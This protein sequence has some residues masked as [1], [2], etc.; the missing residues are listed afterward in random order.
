METLHARPESCASAVSAGRTTPSSDAGS[1]SGCSSRQL[2][3]ALL[4]PAPPSGPLVNGDTRSTDF[5][6]ESAPPLQDVPNL[7]ALLPHMF[8]YF[9][10]ATRAS[11][12]RSKSRPTHPLLAG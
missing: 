5:L 7:E 2:P 4:R 3:A 1:Q 12:R 8:S 9:S 11:G 6:P 10:V